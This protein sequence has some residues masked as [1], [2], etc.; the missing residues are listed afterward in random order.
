MYPSKE[1]RTYSIKMPGEEHYAYNTGPLSE[2]LV[3]GTIF[4]Y[5][6]LNLLVSDLAQEM[7]LPGFEEYK[8]Y[9]YG[10]DLEKQIEK[11]FHRARFFGT[12]EHDT[13]TILSTDA[14][15]AKR[16]AHFLPD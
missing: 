1:Q 9:S 15:V 4:R 8:R 2:S 5:F 6:T 3:P 16:R 11:S 10:L 14:N 13:L 7:P 12:Y